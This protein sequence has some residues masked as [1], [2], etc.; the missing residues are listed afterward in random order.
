LTLTGDPTGGTVAT[1]SI[2]TE[3]RRR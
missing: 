3:L 2:D 1:I